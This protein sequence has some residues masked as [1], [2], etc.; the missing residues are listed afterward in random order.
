MT[1]S[2]VCQ[3]SGEAEYKGR[4]FFGFWGTWSGNSRG[5]PLRPDSPYP[6][7]PCHMTLSRVGFLMLAPGKVGPQ[8]SDWCPPERGRG[9][10]E[11]QRRWRL[12]GAE[13]GIPLHSQGGSGLP[14]AATRQARARAV[15]P[16]SR[17]QNRERR[18]LLPEATRWWRFA[19]ADLGR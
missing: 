8:F 3:K 1:F 10:T 9:R 13:V 19:V 5:E 2:R 6:S 15:H 11:P 4:Q 16:G 18:T 14:P 7:D 17:P 12:G